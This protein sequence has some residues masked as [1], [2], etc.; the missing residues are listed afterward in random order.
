MTDRDSAVAAAQ[1]AGKH[2]G[3]DA[4][5]LGVVRLDDDRPERDPAAAALAEQALA[6]LREEVERMS[7]LREQ[8]AVEAAAGAPGRPTLRL[9]ALAANV[10]GACRFALRLGLITP[11]EAR[12]VWADA[13]TAGLQD[14]PSTDRHGGD[15]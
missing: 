9:D 15:A 12:Q 2:I 3:A 1:A 4:R 10:E 8:L 11:A 13:R 14:R 7:R 5:E 6:V